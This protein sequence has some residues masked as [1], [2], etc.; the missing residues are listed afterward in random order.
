MDASV[1][2]LAL[3]SFSTANRAASAADIIF[4]HGERRRS[5][6]GRGGDEARRLKLVCCC[7]QGRK[8]E[9]L[10]RR[11]HT[12]KMQPLKMV[13]TLVHWSV[14]AVPVR[15]RSSCGSWVAWASRPG[16]SCG[17]SSRTPDPRLAGRR[18][19][20]RRRRRRR[21]GT[22]GGHPGGPEVCGPRR[23]RQGAARDGSEARPDLC[24]RR[25][26]RN[27]KGRRRGRPPQGSPRGRDVLL[28]RDR[29][30]PPRTRIDLP[31]VVSVFF[32]Y[33]GAGKGWF[34]LGR[35]VVL[36]CRFVCLLS[37]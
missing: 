33:F 13:P 11:T 2:I 28:P 27:L 5:S 21:Q 19:S 23:R 6:G 17:S 9:K 31:R 29:R 34:F 15:R 16:S 7:H 4:D 14:V 22:Q 20:R 12:S 32:S 35:R 1:C 3:R 37:R 18:T 10:A 36:S 26:P 25:P 8:T 30:D 24:P